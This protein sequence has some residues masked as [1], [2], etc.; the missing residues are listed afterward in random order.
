MAATCCKLEKTSKIYKIT[1]SQNHFF[2]RWHFAATWQPLGSHLAATWQPLGSHL[3]ATWQPLGSHL[4]ATCSSSH[5][6]AIWQPFAAKLTNSNIYKITFFFKMALG[7][8]LSATCQPLGSH[9]LGQPL[10]SHLPVSHLATTWQP[11]HK[12]LASGCQ[13]A[14]KWLPSGCQVA[15]RARGCK[16]KIKMMHVCSLSGHLPVSSCVWRGRRG[17]CWLGRRW[18]PLA[19]LGAAPLCM[20]G[21]A[22]GDIY[23]HVA[24]VALGESWRHLPS[25]HVASV[26][27]GDIYLRLAW[28]AW[29][30]ETSTCVWRGRRGTGCT[31]CRAWCRAW[32]RLVAVG[33]PG[34]RATL[35][36][37]RGTW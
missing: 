29:H 8:H 25:V 15:D 2:S 17:T 33:G 7:S 9:L 3:A 19:A 22:L 27:L 21:V 4:A 12:H 1:K 11:L 28:Q 34:R 20:A 14:D 24:G 31:W 16:W 32:S 26:A 37:R 30:L 23:F 35:R 13:V 36:G 6:P 10:G 5:V 18:S